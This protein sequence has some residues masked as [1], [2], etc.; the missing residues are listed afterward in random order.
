M[1]DA[2]VHN[3]L[4]AGASGGVKQGP[5]VGHRPLVVHSAAGETHPVGVVQRGRSR[6]GRHQAQLIVEVEGMDVDRRPGGGPVGMPGER[7]HL[8]ARWSRSPAPATAPE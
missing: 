6:Q 7:A 5:R 1:G 2:H 4:H 8:A 3:P